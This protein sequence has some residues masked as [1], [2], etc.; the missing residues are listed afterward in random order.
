MKVI[1]TLL[2][3]FQGA[4]TCNP[5]D[6]TSLELEYLAEFQ[7]EF[8]K[9]QQELLDKNNKALDEQVG[10]N[11][12]V[13]NK[14]VKSVDRFTNYLSKIDLSGKPTEYVSPLKKKD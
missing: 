2:T 13:T 10:K 7:D 8:I 14:Q 1:W 12:E 3:K 9:S 4:F 5:L 6:F 11:K